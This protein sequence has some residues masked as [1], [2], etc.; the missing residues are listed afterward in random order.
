MGTSGRAR[1]APLPSVALTR[2]IRACFARADS[3]RPLR[4]KSAARLALASPTPCTHSL[5]HPAQ[6]LAADTSARG[7]VPPG[8]HVAGVSPSP[9]ADVAEVSPSPGADVAGASPSPRAAATGAGPVLA[10]QLHADRRERDVDRA[11]FCVRLHAE[12]RV[13]RIGAPLLRNRGPDRPPM[14]TLSVCT[15]SASGSAVRHGPAMVRALPGR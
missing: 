15:P 14:H 3:Q 9:G 10:V 8:A 5:W 4:R 11:V 7:T 13:G 12:P 1:P 2:A 6:T